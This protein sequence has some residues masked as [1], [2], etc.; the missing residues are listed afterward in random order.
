M[1][2]ALSF[3]VRRSVSVSRPETQVSTR[4]L[5]SKA[6]WQAQATSW[7]LLLQTIHTIR[8]S[9]R[10]L[11]ARQPPRDFHFARASETKD[12][13]VIWW[14]QCQFPSSRFQ[15]PVSQNH[16]LQLSSPANGL[17]AWTAISTRSTGATSNLFTPTRD[18][19]PLV[20]SETSS[21]TAGK[22]SIPPADILTTNYQPT[23]TNHLSL[24]TA[25]FV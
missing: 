10:T 22:R 4:V 1:V 16:P 17:S 2:T 11:A 13:N 23:T 18:R 12:Q 6:K 19:S 25:P 3:L 14:I 8:A 7:P 20:A 21:E 5:C 24:S 9:Q 15:S